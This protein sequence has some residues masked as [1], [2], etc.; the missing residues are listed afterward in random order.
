MKI[1]SS[2]IK[3]EN[4]SKHRIAIVM[5][6]YNDS[7]GDVLLENTIKTLQKHGLEKIDIIKVPGALEIPFTVNKLMSHNPLP[8]DAM[9]TLGLVIK[10]DTYHFELVCNESYRA[11][12]D[13]NL[14][15]QIPVV[16]GVLTVNN[17]EE[18]KNRVSENGLNKGQ[19]FATCALE[20]IHLNKTVLKAK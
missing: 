15:S 8:Y 2:N 18:A 14:K 5:S 7:L 10:G 19:E 4:F 17:I 1:E 6:R 20:M 3:L 13:I 11:L 9:I 16:F 12:M